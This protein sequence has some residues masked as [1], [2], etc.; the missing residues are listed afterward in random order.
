MK[1]YFIIFLIILTAGCSDDLPNITADL[2]NSDLDIILVIG[3]SNTHYGLGLD[4]SIDGPD[5]RVFQLGRFDADD[6]HI[7][8]AA[9]PL[10]HHSQQQG[11]IGFALSFA[12]QYAMDFLA[13]DGNR[14]VV[15]IPGAEG[16]TGFS[17]NRW[18]KG[19]DLYEDAVQRTQYIT[20]NFPNSR[21]VAILWHQGEADVGSPTYQSDLDRFILDLRG[22]LD[23]QTVPFILGGMV[24]YWVDFGANRMAQ[25]DI[26][27]GTV[28]R[29]ELTGYADPS[30]PWVIEKE[31]NTFDDIHF[32]AAGQRELACRYFWEYERLTD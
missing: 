20:E 24:P 26:I 4:P 28:S 30:L 23:A 16:G 8:E 25:Q 11:R 9:E 21:L 32:D 19:N 27:S 29:V 3:Q 14:N 17:G 31:D 15:I 10:Q 18:N 1:K 13:S 7:I 6:L 2:V 22:D 5:G 12:K